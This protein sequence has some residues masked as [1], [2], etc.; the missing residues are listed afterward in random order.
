MVSFIMYRMKMRVDSENGTAALAIRLAPLLRT[1]DV[2]VL[3]GELGAGKTAFA[4]ALIRHLAGADEEVPSPTFTLA[5][6]YET[7]EITVWHYDL[8]RLAEKEADILELGWEESLRGG[9]SLVEW[10]D[11]LGGLLPRDRLEIKI[12]HIKDSENE[13]D[14][15]LTPHGRFIDRMKGF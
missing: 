14:I 8:Y 13:R 11:R 9:V 7:P 12:S 15:E 5:Q 1:G 6:V 3:A 4:R 2:V 10:A